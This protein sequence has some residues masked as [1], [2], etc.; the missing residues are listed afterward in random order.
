[1]EPR[2]R[3]QEAHSGDGSEGDGIGDELIAGLKDEASTTAAFC[4][5]GTKEDET[6]RACRGAGEPEE[7]REVSEG[8][9]GSEGGNA[10]GERQR[11][12]ALG[13]GKAREGAHVGGEEIGSTRCQSTGGRGAFGVV[14]EDTQKGG[15]MARTPRPRHEKP[16]RRFRAEHGSSER[17]KGR[18]IAK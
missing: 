15:F 6:I 9:A 5:T 8:K 1:M 18:L 17:R 13:R 2:G 10:A 4:S 11:A 7:P 12:R 3:D 16:S 14:D